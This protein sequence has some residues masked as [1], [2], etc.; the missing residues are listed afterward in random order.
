MNL[1][2]K[3]SNTADKAGPQTLWLT[4]NFYLMK[5]LQDLFPDNS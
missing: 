1:N 4:D 2:R 3:V 5:A